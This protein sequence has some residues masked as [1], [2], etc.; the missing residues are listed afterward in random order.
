MLFSLTLCSVGFSTR[1]FIL[2]CLVFCHFVSPFT[3]R[4][5]RLGKRELVFVLSVRLFVLRLLF[6]VSFRF[7]LVSGIGCKL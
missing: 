1:R 5:P 2:S 3:L 7:L 4:L 6:F